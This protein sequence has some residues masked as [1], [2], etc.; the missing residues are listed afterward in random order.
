MKTSNKYL[1]PLLSLFILA[2]SLNAQ[3]QAPE[4]WEEHD[5]TLVG[6]ISH[7]QGQLSRYNPD[8]DDW[9]AAARDEPFGF[10]DLLYA[11]AD[12]K[13]EFLMPNNTWI[14]IGGDT[15]LQLVGLEPDSTELD[16]AFG[17]ARLY[18]KSTKAKIIITTPF[19]HITAPPGSTVD[20]NINEN[21]V[22]IRAIKKKAYFIHNSSPARHEI[23]SNS[24]AML[25]DLNAVTA[26]PG[27]I[28]YAWKKWN[29]QMDAQWAAHLR[30]KDASAAHL[31]AQLHAEAYPLDQ[32]GVWERVYYDGAHYRF[33]RPIRVRADWAPF[34]VGVWSVWH[35]DHVWIPHEPFGY[36]THHYGNWIFTAGFWYWAPPVTRIMIHSHVPRLKIGFGWYPGRVAWIHH[37]A[38]LGWIPLAPREPY[39]SHRHWGR[40]SIV[41]TKGT[42]YR[43]RAHRYRH[44]KHA[45][46]IH[47]S[48]LY[49][50]G[51]YKRT[52]IRSIHHNTIRDNYRTTPVLNAAVIK[53]HGSL[54]KDKSR[55]IPAHKTKLSKHPVKSHRAKQQGRH[56]NFEDQRNKYQPG[57][58]AFDKKQN[59]SG[60]ANHGVSRTSADKRH[61]G[62][63]PS[64]ALNGTT[65]T[66]PS[67][68]ERKATQR[69]HSDNLRRKS[70]VRPLDADQK[71][72]RPAQRMKVQKQWSNTRPEQKNTNRIRRGTNKPPYRE[73]TRP[74]SRKSEK[75]RSSVR[76]HNNGSRQYQQRDGQIRSTR[77]R[78]QNAPGNRS[79]TTANRS[80]TYQRPSA[81]R[82]SKSINRT[83]KQTQ[84]VQRQI[85]QPNFRSQSGRY[86]NP[87]SNQHRQSTSGASRHRNR[88]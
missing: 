3:A 81:P 15:R 49:R 31:P 63:R 55:F 47:R 72:S 2:L 87:G 5:A 6:R 35:G 33:W 42:H 88:N 60:K 28:E 48:H 37:G 68:I 78:M 77:P 82:G 80:P 39:Y 40:R 11:D 7:L 53:D 22:E 24:S 56:S 62:K 57:R 52:R 36:V 41:I 27:K 34:T 13:A 46:V 76:T 79:P 16:I 54:K 26:A 30:E 10:D 85:R 17:R 67:R 83:E 19:G 73:A 69:R 75:S 18:N 9:E 44:H 61:H 29:Q 86:H 8:T 58:N 38:H 23:R 45:V 64:K 51:N 65:P 70:D 59:H 74:D 12:V 66:A 43:H 71:K 21:H 25:A 50:S 4:A 84:S 20:L 1:V 14:R 32:H